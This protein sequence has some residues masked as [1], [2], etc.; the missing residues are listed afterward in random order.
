MSRFLFVTWNGAGNQSPTIGFAQ[1]LQDR[2]HEVVSAGFES[3][4]AHF[5]E[6]G[7][8]FA[9]LEASDKAAREAMAE[10]DI[11]R[12]MKSAVM[13]GAQ[14]LHE[15]PQLF[16][17]EHAD[18]LVVDCMMFGALAAS[19]LRGLPSAVFVHSAPGA[20]FGFDGAFGNQFLPELNALRAASGLPSVDRTWHAWRGMPVITNSIPQIDPLA[21]KAAPEFHYVGPI[22][23]RSR[24]PTWRPPWDHDDERPLVLVSFS[25]S[26]AGQGQRSKLERTL[27]GLAAVP[28]RILATFSQADV[29]DLNV[30]DNA[31]LM[32]H[33]PHAEVLPQ[34][35]VTVT[36]A[37]HGT[38]IAA[39]TYGVPLVCLPQPLRPPDQAPLAR[40]V[41]AIGAGRALDGD[42]A[43]PEEI[44]EAVLDILS[45][46]SYRAR[47]G[48]LADSIR[49]MPGAAGAATIAEG[50]LAAN[51][52]L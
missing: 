25:T 30:P 13:L 14:Q 44:A 5:Q 52:S 20:L 11:P 43:T 33:V 17:Q 26:A 4:R 37:G 10:L 39:L 9:L 19:E 2:G 8:P 45:T 23:E 28:C 3:Q 36:H 48:E 46:P 1:A 16:T 21:D 35:S 51:S 24:P 42:E 15:I 12:Y 34:A 27:I 7:V 18:A 40:Q 6:R 38:T 29:A 41:E 47:A 22:F 32:P 50:L 31:I 49:T